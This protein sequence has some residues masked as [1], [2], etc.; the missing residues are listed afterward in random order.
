ML[1]VLQT[2]WLDYLEKWIVDMDTKHTAEFQG[3]RTEDEHQVFFALV[4][5]SVRLLTRSFYGQQ[6]L[7]QTKGIHLWG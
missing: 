7:H 6:S 5:T 3:Q 1:V 2:L 4:L